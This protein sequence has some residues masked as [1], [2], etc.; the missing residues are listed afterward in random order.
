MKVL[1]QPEL[2][3]G[4]PNGDVLIAF[5]NAVAGTDRAALDGARAA[6]EARMG[7]NALVEAALVAA[8]F[9]MLDR[10]ANAIGIPMEEPFIKG[11]ADFR[12]DIGINDFLSAGNTLSAAD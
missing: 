12:A 1:T 9:S 10:I 3:S 8:N 11:T 4:V 2:D 6:L 5:T 7:P